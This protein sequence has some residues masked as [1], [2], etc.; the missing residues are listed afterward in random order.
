MRIVLRSNVV[1]FKR[2][3]LTKWFVEQLMAWD[4]VP[5]NVEPVATVRK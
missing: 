1:D 4:S 5:K 2:G 3:D